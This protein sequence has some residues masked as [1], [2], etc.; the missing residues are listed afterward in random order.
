[1]LNDKKITAEQYRDALA[2][3]V[4][5]LPN[6]GRG[7]KAPHFVMYVIDYLTQKYGKRCTRARWIKSNHNSKL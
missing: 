5:F 1:M 3:K 2:E 7:I 6:T 4:E